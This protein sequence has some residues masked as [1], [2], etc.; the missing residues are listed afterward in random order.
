MS[1]AGWLSLAF[2]VLFA[3]AVAVCIIGG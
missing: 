3:F 2:G 1:L